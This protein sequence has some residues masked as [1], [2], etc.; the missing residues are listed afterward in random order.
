MDGDIRKIIAN[1]TCNWVSSSEPLDTEIKT[2]KDDIKMVSAG[3]L[4]HIVITPIPK[5]SLSSFIK[6]QDSNL[7]FYICTY[8]SSPYRSN[9]IYLYGVNLVKC[10]ILMFINDFQKFSVF[11]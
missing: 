3:M 9:H 10:R 8:E 6:S 4:K 1:K 11:S 7:E 5:G 2:S